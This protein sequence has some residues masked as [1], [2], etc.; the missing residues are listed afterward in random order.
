MK[1]YLDGFERKDVT[2]LGLGTVSKDYTVAITD[3][4]KVKNG[5]N[6]SNFFG[7]CTHF[8]NGMASVTIKGYT[9]VKFTGTAPSV[10]FVKLVCDGKGGVKTDDSGREILVV[11]VD[12]AE[13]VCGVIL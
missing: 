9:V 7:V 1:N 6:G 5:A 13:G 4:F 11:A 12:T 2:L 8:A 10:G 3:S